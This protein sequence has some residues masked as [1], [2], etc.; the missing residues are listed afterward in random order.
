LL[1][2]LKQ[3]LKRELEQKIRDDWTEEQAVDD[4]ERQLQGKGFAKLVVDHVM[5]PQRPA[6]KLLVEAVTSL[7]G[8]TLEG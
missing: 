7:V 5:C 3:R 2:L 6:Q 4:I 1:R 8:D